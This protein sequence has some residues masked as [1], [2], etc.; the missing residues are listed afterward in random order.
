M[1]WVFRRSWLLCPCQAVIISKLMAYALFV[2]D[3]G[4]AYKRVPTHVELTCCGDG[5]AKTIQ[6]VGMIGFADVDHAVINVF[7]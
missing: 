6:S 3:L 2:G 7:L 4:H 5:L 1:G